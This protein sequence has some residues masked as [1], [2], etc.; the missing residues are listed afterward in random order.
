MATNE[1]TSVIPP[2]LF[3]ELQQAADRAAAGVRDP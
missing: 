2:E 3:A 1:T